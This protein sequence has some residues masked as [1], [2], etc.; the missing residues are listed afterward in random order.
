METYGE[1]IMTKQELYQKWI[2]QEYDTKENIRKAFFEDVDK[3]Y[4]ELRAD[5]ACYILSGIQEGSI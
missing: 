3:V 1:T 5:E 2:I 4:L